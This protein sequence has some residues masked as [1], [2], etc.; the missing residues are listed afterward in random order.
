M[1]LLYTILFICR[2]HT[3]LNYETATGMFAISW[4]IYDMTHM[5]QR[6]DVA[7]A[8]AR[9]KDWSGVVRLFGQYLFMGKRQGARP[10]PP[11]VFECVGQRL[12][13][14][15]LV[16]DRSE[17][18]F[19]KCVGNRQGTPRNCCACR[20]P[21]PSN[22]HHN[23]LIIQFGIFEVVEVEKKAQQPSHRIVVFP[24]AIP[25][26]KYDQSKQ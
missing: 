3:H 21:L 25:P 5:G 15:Q 11:L 7:K 8:P 9:R 16:G 24:S 20:R 12:K 13:A 19:R 22:I 23:Q 4:S 10:G 14:V 2:D 17:T 18:G 1:V 26:S 6:K